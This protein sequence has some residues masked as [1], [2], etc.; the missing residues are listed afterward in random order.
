MNS[1]PEPAIVILGE[2]GK[3]EERVS[4]ASKCLPEYDPAACWNGDSSPFRYWKIRD[5]AH[6]YR[7]GI[8]TP[9]IVS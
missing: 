3:A 9:S 4:L 5:Y 6:A 7:S 8:T 2:D 1:E